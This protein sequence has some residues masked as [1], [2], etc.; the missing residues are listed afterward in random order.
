M[1][2]NENVGV[3]FSFALTKTYSKKRGERKEGEGSSLLNSEA[4]TTF[5]TL[6]I[7]NQR[8]YKQKRA[9]GEAR[10]K[11]HDPSVLSFWGKK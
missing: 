7:S 9:E 3:L 11:T 5:D 1:S 2:D 6:R 4:R 10:T 8:S